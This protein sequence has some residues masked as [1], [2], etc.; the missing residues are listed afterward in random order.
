MPALGQAAIRRV[1]D[2]G[3]CA[4]LQ[5]DPARHQRDRGR[6]APLAAGIRFSLRSAV[7]V[8]VAA[9]PY[10]W[11]ISIWLVA[12]LAACLAVIRAI[13]PGPE[14]LLIA[15]AFP[16]VFVAALAAISFVTL[17]AGD[18]QPARDALRSRLRPRGARGRDCIFCPPRNEPRFSHVHRHTL[19]VADDAGGLRFHL[20]AHGAR[21]RTRQPGCRPP[22]NR[23][24][25]I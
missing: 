8:L 14:T 13:L 1:A 23:T 12:S 5:P 18:R 24:T 19:G 4:R 3:A 11:G 2:L 10:G 22:W 20:A 7:A 17:G 15:A 16:A 6:D 9:V 25:V 21:S